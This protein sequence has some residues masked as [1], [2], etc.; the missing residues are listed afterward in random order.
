MKN[1]IIINIDRAILDV[2]EINH[3]RNFKNFWKQ[4][5]LSSKPL[6]RNLKLFGSFALIATVAVEI[7]IDFV[8]KPMPKIA[9]HTLKIN[10]PISEL[11][12]QTDTFCIDAEKGDT[13]TY[14]TGSQIIIPS[15]CFVDND[16][17]KI[18]GKINIQYREF[19][20]PVDIIF[21]GIPMGYDSGGVR[22][23]FES[24]G[25]IE[26]K[27]FQNNKS[28]FIKESQSISINMAS[29]IEKSGINL[30]RFDTIKN[31]WVMLGKDSLNDGLAE[32][33]EQYF[34]SDKTIAP[35]DSIK[36]VALNYIKRKQEKKKTL[37][38]KPIAP[39]LEN[40]SKSS[41]VIDFDREDFAELCSFENVKFEIC[42]STKQIFAEDTATVWEAVNLKQGGSNNYMVT[43]ST[44]ERTLKYAVKPVFDKLNIANAKLIFE[45]K[46]IAYNKRLQVNKIE[47]EFAQKELTVQLLKRQQALADAREK[48]IKEDQEIALV[49]KKARKEALENFEKKQKKQLEM[50]AALKSLT[51][52]FQVNQFGI[53]NCDKL[54]SS[55]Y[56]NYNMQ[57]SWIG[58]KEASISQLYI[59]YK[60]INGA[61]YCYPN[62][63]VNNE[64]ILRLNK[65]STCK[66]VAIF[67]NKKIGICESDELLKNIAEKIPNAVLEIHEI[68]L[69][70][71]NALNKLINI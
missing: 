13:I 55:V 1:N 40:S 48:A 18:T 53:Y 28:V 42:D 11:D 66:L 2:A 63:V 47:A 23:Q 68:D 33:A 29:S 61:V 4:Y 44:S 56:K 10:I 7:A 49:Q 15:H 22:N 16:G 20:N 19:C 25:M 17:N 70:D 45:Q 60:D 35:Y 62:N 51:R 36:L 8:K 21:S 43:F 41:F 30:Y 69:K 31:N 37:Q 58:D 34:T 52:S 65:K 64:Y 14:K 50:A 57:L 27:G 38:F 67:D 46:Y 71:Q 5:Y 12:V 24:A 9:D 54:I 6:F 26:I 3:Q 39:S 32:H 59:I